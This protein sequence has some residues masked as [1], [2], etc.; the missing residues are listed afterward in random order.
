MRDFLKYFKIMHTFYDQDAKKFF[1]WNNRTKIFKK[2]EF[3]EKN[4]GSLIRLI[5]TTL[6]RPQLSSSD[7]NSL[8]INKIAIKILD[9]EPNFSL[10]NVP[11]IYM[12]LL[13]LSQCLRKSFG[14]Y[15][16]LKF[17]FNVQGTKILIF[18]NRT[19]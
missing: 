11:N 19:I 3:R 9:S 10:P 7:A 1:R 15:S 5:R 17:E 14:E 16:N 18:F 6:L 12:Y 2:S 8:F 4:L 13:T